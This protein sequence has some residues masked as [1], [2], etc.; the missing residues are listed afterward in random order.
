[1]YALI[2]E[3]CGFNNYLMEMQMIRKPLETASLNVKMYV[4]LYQCFVNH[5]LAVCNKI[6]N[7]HFR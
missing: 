1:M 4:Y 3:I 2:I 7:M 6:I 5:M